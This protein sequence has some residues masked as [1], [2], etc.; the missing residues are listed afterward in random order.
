MASIKEKLPKT[1]EKYE[2]KD[3]TYLTDSL[4]GISKEAMELHFK[5]YNG[6]VMKT[7][8]INQLLKEV[9]IS[10]ANHNYSDLRE[11]LI[12]KSHNLNGVILHELFFSNL[13]DDETKPSEILKSVVER[14]FGSWDKYIENIKACAKASRAGWA[15]SAYNFRD[16]K[17]N[18]FAID[19]HDLHMP[20]FV[21]PILI[22][23]VWEHAHITDYGID[24]PAY[25]DAIFENIDWHVVSRRLEN[26]F[27][28]LLSE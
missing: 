9:D 22:I 13:T 2:T 3:F 26:Q 8:Q 19:Q 28:D 14:D 12:E 21:I 5:L 25:I 23:D 15:I 7:N 16:G 27:S 17:I 20:A 18:N 1:V 10:T 6:Y 11:L 4:K 24:K